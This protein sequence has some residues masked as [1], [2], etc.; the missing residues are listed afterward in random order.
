MSERVTLKIDG[1]TCGGCE[2]SLKEALERLDG[3]QVIE[4]SHQEGTAEVLYEPEHASI[5]ALA[6]AVD[7]AGYDLISA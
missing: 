4:V 3:V 1:M 7:E 6:Q 2:S 5:D